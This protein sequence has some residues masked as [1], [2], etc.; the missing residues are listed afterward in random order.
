M[1]INQNLDIKSD[2]E[3]QIVINYVNFLERYIKNYL[4]QAISKNETLD[5]LYN[6]L[7]SGEIR[8][9]DDLHSNLI[10]LLEIKENLDK[11]DFTDNPEVITI[12][13]LDIR[14]SLASLTWQDNKISEE[15][16][17]T[18]DEISKLIGFDQDSNDEGL[19]NKYFM[20]YKKYKLKYLNLKK[21]SF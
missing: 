10:N 17:N 8:I 2:K 12:D 3:K 6:R 14:E 18:I 20:L 7:I 9:Q 15:D 13:T 19:D 4:S 21:L 1:N 11:K 16:R 5:D